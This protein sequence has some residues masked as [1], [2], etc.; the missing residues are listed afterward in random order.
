VPT[1]GNTPDTLANAIHEEI[2]KL[3]TTDISDDELRMIKTR[4]KADLIR[5]LGDNEGLAQQL[6]TYQGMMGD[7]R[8][9]FR[10]EERL[11]KV[12]KADVRRVAAK[13]FVP[14]NRT[15]A[16]IESVKPPAGPAKQGGE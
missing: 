9:L 10:N 12:T 15:V 16:V 13:T 3:K 7:W 11:E 14:N 8:E 4:G 6:G 1:Q 2:E 5:G